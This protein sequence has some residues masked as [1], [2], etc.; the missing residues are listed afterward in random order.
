MESKYIY[1][2]YLQLFQD[3]GISKTDD[4]EERTISPPAEVVDSLKYLKGEA[5]T[6]FKNLRAHNYD[7]NKVRNMVKKFLLDKSNDGSI[8]LTSL[9]KIGDLDEKETVF[10]RG[11]TGVGFYSE[12]AIQAAVPLETTDVIA[13]IMGLVD[14]AAERSSSDLSKEFYTPGG[15][16]FLADMPD[17]SQLPAIQERQ[18]VQDFLDKMEENKKFDEQCFMMAYLNNY[19]S[20]YKTKVVEESP[21]T[22]I[23]M[24]ETDSSTSIINGFSNYLDIGALQGLTNDKLSYLYPKI[25]LHKVYVQKTDKGFKTLK[26]KPFVFE[27]SESAQEIDNILESNQGRGTGVGIQNFSWTYTGD[28]PATAQRL[29][30]ASLDIY[31]QDLSFFVRGFPSSMNRADYTDLISF[32]ASKN[33]SEKPTVRKSKACDPVEDEALSTHV[34]EIEQTEVE[35]RVGWNVPADA[36]ERFTPH[37]LDA[38][39]SC[40]TTI[41]MITKDYDFKFEQDGTVVLSVQ[42]IGRLEGIL[43]TNTANLFAETDAEKNM[44]KTAESQI[45]AKQKQEG[46]PIRLEIDKLKKQGTDEGDAIKRLEIDANVRAL[47]AAG[48]TL[49]QQISD[50]NPLMSE[51]RELRTKRFT[52]LLEHIESSDRIFFLKLDMATI[53]NCVTEG[54]GSGDAAYSF[55]ASSQKAPEPFASTNIEKLKDEV[56][57]KIESHRKKAVDTAGKSKNKPK[58]V[59]DG[60]ATF[61]MLDEENHYIFPYIYVGDIINAAA[62]ILNDN[63][64]QDVVKYRIVTSSFVYRDLNCKRKVV[65]IAD[66]PISLNVFTNWYTDN[67][68]AKLRSSLPFVKFVRKLMSDLVFK[69]LGKAC[70]NDITNNFRGATTKINTI[71][72]SP[73]LDKKLM[74]LRRFRASQILEDKNLPKNAEPGKSYEYIVLSTDL[75]PLNFTGDRKADE[76]NG[77]MHFHVGR[78]RGLVKKIEFTKMSIPGLREQYITQGTTLDKVRLP[79]NTSVTLIGYPHIIPGC[80]FYVDP[81]FSGMGDTKNQNSV[82]RK[83]GL[84]GYYV[85]TAVSNQIS[86]GI[87]TTEVNGLFESF[88]KEAPTI[89]QEEANVFERTLKADG[90]PTNLGAQDI[91]TSSAVLKQ[92]DAEFTKTLTAQDSPVNADAKE[93]IVIEAIIDELLEKA[94]KTRGELTEEEVRNIVSEAARLKSE[95][96]V[97]V[98][99]KEGG[100]LEIES[101]DILEPGKSIVEITAEPGSVEERKQRYMAHYLNR[102]PTASTAEALEWATDTIALEDESAPVLDGSTSTPDETDQQPEIPV[103]TEIQKDFLRQTIAGRDINTLE[104]EII[105]YYEAFNLVGAGKNL[106]PTDRELILEAGADFFQNM[107]MVNID[108]RDK[109]RVLVVS[110]DISRTRLVEY[111]NPDEITSSNMLLA[112]IVIEEIQGSRNVRGNVTLGGNA[113]AGKRDKFTSMDFTGPNANTVIEQIKS[114]IEEYYGT[115]D[116]DN[117]TYEYHVTDRT[118][119]F[120][121][122]ETGMGFYARDESLQSLENQL[123]TANTRLEAKR[124][125]LINSPF[126]SRVVYNRL[127]EEMSDA[128]LDFER[129]SHKIAVRNGISN[130]RTIFSFDVESYEQQLLS[131]YPY[132]GND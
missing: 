113:K 22:N 67:F 101:I 31:I 10:Q 121:R 23:L 46:K 115:G 33:S 95:N 66:I 21:N 120:Q 112:N 8:F 65:N 103:Q 39:R 127:I 132:R 42:Y 97:H 34:N 48:R 40:T 60:L 99:F 27:T 54:I 84:G 4:L 81:T 83:L 11:E 110:G 73:E 131:D 106:T 102:F 61:A 43:E 111:L 7:E 128:K 24:A 118:P 30:E 25:E 20:F 68:I 129:I 58:G 14:D 71:T 35:A 92:L 87:Y 74:E 114:E 125:R 38:I 15:E 26:T 98:V 76:S 82:A 109:I 52:A 124:N 130:Q 78:D 70:F 57:K 63:L 100:S 9:R 19:A 107:E 62:K 18:A 16:D 1:T 88:P 41:R 13:I 51:Y 5:K 122:G 28:N 29:V 2:T 69:A 59:T 49:M 55:L 47:N 56:K 80:K 6:I 36:T 117:V 77:L 96:R 64:K 104:T 105:K 75:Y 93:T 108:G 3:A 32:A 17:Y 123:A 85:A 94:N 119:R 50:S 89:K 116:G 37:E 12:E 126:I 86:N 91:N 53:A 90:I 44:R 72:V 45:D 79:F